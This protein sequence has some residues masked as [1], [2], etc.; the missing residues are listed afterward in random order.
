MPWQPP[1]NPDLSIVGIEQTQGIQFFNFD[2]Q[3]SG[4]R[5]DNELYLVPTKETVLRVYINVASS[6]PFE[7]TVSYTGIAEA[8]SGENPTLINDPIRLRIPAR[9]SARSNR[10]DASS[11]L[12]F[13]LPA[14]RCTGL[15]T[16]A[17]QFRPVQ[18][19]VLRPPYPPSAPVYFQLNFPRLKTLVGDLG[20]REI[21]DYRLR[22]VCVRIIYTGP[23]V[24]GPRGPLTDQQVS[25]ALSD[26]F[27]TRT[28]P[29]SGINYTS[30]P[31]PVEFNGDLRVEPDGWV[32][33]LQ[34]LRELRSVSGS[35]DVYLGLLPDGVPI[36][37]ISGRGE[38]DGVA[39]AFV[40]RNGLSEIDVVAHE[41]GH[42]YGRWHAPCGDPDGVDEGYPRYAGFKDGSIGEFGFDTEV[43]AIFDP[44]TAVDFM[45]VEQTCPEDKNPRWIS[46][47]TFLSERGGGLLFAIYYRDWIYHPSAGAPIAPREAAEE[48]EYLYLNFRMYRDG[49]VQLLP[50]VHLSGLA[51]EAEGS[52][53]A[54]VAFELRDANRQVLGFYRCYL[55]DPNV[56]PDSPYRDFHKMVPWEDPWERETRTIAFFRDGEEVDEVEVEEQAPEIE[57]RVSAHEPDRNRMRLE[58]EGQHETKSL[59]YLVRYSNDGGENWVGLAAGLTEPKFVVDDLDNLPGGERCVFQIA[60]S[61]TIRTTVAETEPV[62][63][64]VTPRR[65][66]I[67]S[68]EPGATFLQGESVTLAG[69]GY[70]PDFETAPLD[71]VVW[72]SNV[73][74]FIGYGHEIIT[75]TLAPGSHKITLGVADGLG[76]EASADVRIRINPKEE[77]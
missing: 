76:G 5:P 19:D 11:T 73:A 18:P 39:A 10:G 36:G 55:T 26:S 29:I 17:V 28:F 60:A 34:K 30:F 64:P 31:P 71:E 38:S 62:S 54:S 4:R 75:E 27:L 22:L 32:A 20:G 50:S 59:T 46:P 25:R 44:S 24:I 35:N 2:G 58:W 52:P 45:S 21:T 66:Y 3:G 15:R 14:W 47:H 56:D 63:V 7:S 8:S 40:V 13:R 33:L 49:K 74:G 48:R 16:V 1:Y 72:T 65:P 70:S 77:E 51:P 43:S 67:V 69:V 57:M 12:N 23:G 42:A 37:T 41:L 61:S 6:L 68:P 9:S 53:R